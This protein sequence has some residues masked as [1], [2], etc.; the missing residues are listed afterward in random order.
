MFEDR[1]MLPDVSSIPLLDK[2]C[3]TPARVELLTWLQRNAPSLA[4]LY[5]GAVDLMYAN[6]FPGRVRF[7]SHAVREIRNRLP[8]ISAGTTRGGQLQ[9]KKRMDD[10]AKAWKNAG[11]NLDE[12][13]PSS[14]VPTEP[15]TLSPS[16]WS[17]SLK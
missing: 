17:E 11:F 3:W 15:A 16:D 13:I 5:Q 9:Y 4:E 10:L 1:K 6:L 7:V 2:I 12:S 14:L 8:D